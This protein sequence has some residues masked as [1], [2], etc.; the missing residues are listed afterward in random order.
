M[1]TNGTIMWQ[2]GFLATSIY[3]RCV[4]KKKKNVGR[5]ENLNYARIYKHVCDVDSLKT[6]CTGKNEN[7][8]KKNKK[9]IT[10]YLCDPFL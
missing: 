3:Y 9:I 1:S 7:K 5:D 4:P 10:R 6:V 2:P 8:T